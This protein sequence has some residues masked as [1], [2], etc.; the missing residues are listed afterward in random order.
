MGRC[1]TVELTQTSEVVFF[2]KGDVLQAEL[3]GLF[4]VI[5]KALDS[6]FPDPE[7]VVKGDK[8]EVTDCLVEFV[9]CFALSKARQHFWDIH[10]DGKFFYDGWVLLSPSMEHLCQTRDELVGMDDFGG[11]CPF[12]QG[13]RRSNGRDRARDCASAD[14]LVLTVISRADLGG[15]PREGS[16]PV[17]YGVSCK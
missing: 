12:G 1:V 15:K 9:G 14:L 5:S 7:E 6:V 11:V 16:G 4:R 3:D 17:L 8:G 2:E 10:F 13:N